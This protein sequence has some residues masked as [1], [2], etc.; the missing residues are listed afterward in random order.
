MSTPPNPTVP[1]QETKA[2]QSILLSDYIAGAEATDRFPKTEFQPILLGLYGEVGSV[3]S[4]VK[5][6]KRDK[7]AFI[8]Y[9]QAVEEEFGDALWYFTA[10]CSR[11]GVSVDVIL[12]EAADNGKYRTAIAA[13]GLVVGPLS[14]VSTVVV[15]P[16]LDDVLLGLGRASAHLLSV[17]PADSEARKKLADFADC[18]LHALQASGVSFAEVV[19]LNLAK[20]QGRFLNP[21]PSSLPTF[22][23]EFPDDERI[24]LEFEIVIKE[25]KSG[26]SCMQW[27]GVFIGDP[28]TDNIRDPDGY[29]FHDV[30]HFAHAA[31]LHW[32]PTFRALIKHKRKSDPQMD[33]AQDSGRAIVVEEGLSAWIFSRA[34][35]LKFFD[36]QGSVSFDLLKT[37][38]QFV[39][40]YEVE[41]CPLKLWEDAILQG[42][43]VF[44]Q[45][46]SNNGG[47][48]IGD[49]TNRRIAYRS[50]QGKH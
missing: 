22:D 17:S 49:R 46:R 8:G 13:S 1:V 50:L 34:K 6:H 36:G 7:D 44:R 41:S 30:F 5:K 26:Q 48:V 47:V 3:M 37:V 4:A 15:M 29:R 35:L 16:Q 43:N 42:Y 28:L 19:R 32:S 38:G 27:N 31:I 10:L 24:P 25:R 11:L 21:D 18:Y 20:V 12:A 14:Q 45:I 33:E 9:R 23:M 40:G 2:C 39:Q